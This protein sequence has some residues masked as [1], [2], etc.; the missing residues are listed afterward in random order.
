MRKK[1]LAAAMAAGVATGIA[2][3]TAPAANATQ[4]GNVICYVT[5]RSGFYAPGSIKIW[6]QSDNVARLYKGHCTDEP[7]AVQNNPRGFFIEYGGC[8]SQ[9]GHFYGPGQW[10]LFKTDNNRLELGCI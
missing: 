9:W 5:K 2:I 3:A 7:P 10:F 4:V 1:I 6:L 8:Y